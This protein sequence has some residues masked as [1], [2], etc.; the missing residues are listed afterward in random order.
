MRIRTD[1][2]F[3]HRTEEIEAAADWWDCNKSEALLRSAEFVRW[4]EPAIQDVLERDDLTTQQKRE[5]AEALSV[6]GLQVGV[7]ETVAVEK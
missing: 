4:I 2:K 3:A 6:G 5:I 1:G 7:E